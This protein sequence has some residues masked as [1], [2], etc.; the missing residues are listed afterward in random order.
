[1][2]TKKC[3]AIIFLLL[4]SV[5][6]IESY[7]PPLKAESESEAMSRS[8]FKKD[9][10]KYYKR[11]ALAYCLGYDFAKGKIY[12][13]CKGKEIRKNPY[14]IENMVE[15]FGDKSL[16]D[17]IRKY[18]DEKTLSNEVNSC[19]GLIYY[20]Q[21]FHKMLENFLTNQNDLN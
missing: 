1:M 14:H 17:K 13:V 16:V 20:Y 7:C 12:Q 15:D 2:N 10:I 3:L 6:T 19:F 4:F 21:E 8:H 5:N 18:I 9:P 11:Y